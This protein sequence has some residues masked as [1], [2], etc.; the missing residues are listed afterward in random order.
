MLRRCAVT[1]FVL[2]LSACVLS[3]AEV[4]VPDATGGSGGSGGAGGLS[5]TGGAGGDEAGC[6][7]NFDCAE[8]EY[9]F[10]AS[11]GGLGTCELRPDDC[12]LNVAFVCGCDGSTY[13]NACE[14]SVAG[15][16]IA[17]EGECVCE[18]N[19][20][21][22]EEEYCE[23]ESCE[24]PG[25]CEPRPLSCQV[26]FAP[27]CGC[28]GNTYDNECLAETAGVRIEADGPCPCTDN[29]PCEA[30]EYCAAD[31]CDVEGTCVDRPTVCP[32]ILAPVCG[33]DNNTYSNSCTAQSAGVNVQSDNEC[34]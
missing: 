18:T 5:G 23:G 15:V 19:D 30:D 17:A 31:G 1:C 26:I 32:L 11:C 13:D 4:Q 34:P 33:C 12:P 3:C 10:S 29:S 25:T 6:A 9:C 27:V 28:D 24:G 16:R 20:D 8:E 7:T 21:C 14:A 22:I 2:C